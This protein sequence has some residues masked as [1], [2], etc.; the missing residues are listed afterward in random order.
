VTA[1]EKRRAR[2]R[3]RFAAIGTIIHAIAVA[4]Q[5]RAAAEAAGEV[6][7]ADEERARVQAQLEANPLP[8]GVLGPD[9]TAAEIKTLRVGQRRKNGRPPKP[10]NSN[11]ALIERL[12]TRFHDLLT[13][14]AT[15]DRIADMQDWLR[16]QPDMRHRDDETLARAI[17][18]AKRKG[19][20]PQ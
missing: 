20:R 4:A 15:A 2:T 3:R 6:L 18:R 1:H 11:D 14:P 9:E 12:H 17:R 13:A 19:R 10:A 5:V 8:P 7:T 16:T